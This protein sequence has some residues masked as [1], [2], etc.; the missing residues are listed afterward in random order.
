MAIPLDTRQIE[1]RAN[2]QQATGAVTGFSENL[3]SAFDQFRRENL[4]T[5]E[6][7]QWGAEWQ[8][9]FDL[10]KKH[11]VDT[12]PH[13]SSQADPGAVEWMKA[14]PGHSLPEYWHQQR[15]Q[16]FNE[17]KQRFPDAGFK[18]NI[19]MFEGM[20]SRLAGERAEA[21]RV[22]ARASGTGQL[23][24]FIGDVG[25][26]VSDPVV[27][28]TLPFGASSGASILRAALTEAALASATEA[29]IQPQIA[30]FR[31]AI[32]NPQAEGEA[33]QNIL[34]AGGGTAALVTALKGIPMGYR[35]LADHYRKSVEE[36]RL[37]PTVTEQAA[38][39]LLDRHA[40][41]SESN[42]YNRSM[43]GATEAH[44]ANLRKADNAAAE[45][46]IVTGKDLE[47][48]AVSKTGGSVFERRKDTATRKRL[49]DMTKEEL[50]QE[51]KID[52]LSG[53]SS[54]RAF[55][56]APK[57]RFIASIDLDGLKFL[58]DEM[59]HG[60]GDEMLKKVGKAIA[61]AMGGTDDAFRKGGDEFAAQANSEKALN[62]A[63]VKAQD[64]LKRAKIK[65]I[66]PDGSII[67]KHGIEF[68]F[69]TGRTF[70]EADAKLKSEK[71]AR[72][73]RGERAERGAEPPGLVRKPGRAAGRNAV[74]G[75]TPARVGE[76]GP[77][78]RGTGENRATPEDIELQVIEAD[79]ALVGEVDALLLEKPDLKVAG[80]DTVDESGNLTTS[81]VTAAR[82]LED[83]AEEQRLA[84]EFEA[85]VLGPAPKEAAA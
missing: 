25:G 10:A 23:G 61:D 26:A 78:P 69:T 62:A 8:Q 9:Q 53:L 67:E 49:E 29:S 51:V 2:A 19:E 46:G 85:C 42:P 7:N 56:A 34:L 82:L 79:E 84:K 73:A 72:T 30:Q 27:A 39:D 16:Q 66:K 5:S 55:E 65:V 74:R 38:L 22:R 75:R 59:G 31:A 48:P 32:G 4:S 52:K 43:E 41:E 12:V 71:D 28:L 20:T 24:A 15:E 13:F 17:L 60:A 63:M 64:R 58:N 3:F 21:N 44:A 77:V 40:S 1:S 81:T 18:T 37:K 45:G 14:N 70:D 6:G 80:A 11:G 76:A 57:K 83:A 54:W 36:G 50:L 35:A 68:S 47:A 33:L